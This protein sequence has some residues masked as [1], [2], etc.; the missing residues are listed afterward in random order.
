MLDFPIIPL[1]YIPGGKYVYFDPKLQI[2]LYLTAAQ[3]KE[4][5]LR[6]IAKEH[7][8][9]R[10]I[11]AR[12]AVGKHLLIQ[13]GTE[14]SIDWPAL[15]EELT[16]ECRSKGVFDVGLA[17]GRGLWQHSSG[18]LVFNTGANLQVTW[19]DGRIDTKPLIGIEA[20]DAD[21][22]RYVR[23]S[24]PANPPAAVE[25]T[26]EECKAALAALSLFS[27]SRGEYDAKLFLGWLSCSTILNLLSFRPQ[28][29]LSAARGAGK[30]TVI[31]MLVQMLGS[32][33]CLHVEADISSEAGIRQTLGNDALPL[34]AD[35]FETTSPGAKAILDFCR[36]ASNPSAGGVL[37]GSPEGK[38]MRFD[39][40]TSAVVAGIAITM[41]N[42]ADSSRFAR[43]ELE[44]RSHSGEER[45]TLAEAFA[46][47]D[48]SFGAR[49]C[50]RMIKRRSQFLQTLAVLQEALRE[51]G[52]DTRQTDLY[53]HLLAGYWTACHD[54]SISDE[55]AIE[56]VHLL[57][58][59]EEEPE[60]GC[61]DHLLGHQI[62][63]DEIGSITVVELL[64]QVRTKRGDHINTKDLALIGIKY[65]AQH[66][67]VL[68]ANSN[69][70]L[71]RIFASTPWRDGQHAKTLKRMGGDGNGNRSE[72]FGPY[73]PCKVTRL[74]AS[75]IFGE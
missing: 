58:E 71:G 39:I 42:P 54:A 15:A 19:P 25:A 22:S 11:L 16:A 41:P 10:A 38:A 5:E 31:R 35:E 46:Q 50:R 2:L 61:L 75:Q 49:L 55:E 17:R 8:W 18:A 6:A 26:A 52:M 65:D 67:A 74:A 53:G 72:R 63:Q 9:K 3:H 20:T 12:G 43:I 40:R 68:I 27:F 32:S 45:R 60:R 36:I 34:L 33:N 13:R 30:S 7:E 1:G 64:E 62:Y 51:I 59:Q 57:R 56:L 23:S 69:P 70:G 24:P 44:K 14:T 66:D 47:F 29:A 28:V 37:K 4:T 73:P 48:S 21:P